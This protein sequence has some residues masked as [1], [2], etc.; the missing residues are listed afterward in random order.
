MDLDEIRAIDPSEPVTLTIRIFHDEPV[1]VGPLAEL[2]ESLAVVQVLAT[3]EAD[4]AAVYF[5]EAGERWR[6]RSG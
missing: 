3:P 6:L 1:E 5:D 2:L 4:H